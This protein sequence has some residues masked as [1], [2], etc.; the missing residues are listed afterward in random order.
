MEIYLCIITTALVLTQ[1]IRLC[2]N[3][4]QLR[5][6]TEHEIERKDIMNKWDEM[7]KA[8]DRLIEKG[9]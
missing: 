1:I 6:Q 7:T 5:L 9:E 8:I 3:T 4:V 2:Q